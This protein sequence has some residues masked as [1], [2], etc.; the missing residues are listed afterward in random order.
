M[1]NLYNTLGVKDNATQEE[2]K[3]A[4]RKLAIK[5]HPD[6]G[7]NEDTFKKV[8]EAYGIL[9]DD[10][11]RSQY[12]NRN[13]NPFGGNPFGGQGGG[14]DPFGDFFRGFTQRRKK[15]TAPETI[16][17]VDV[18]AV[19]S[20]LGSEKIIT[21]TKKDKCDTCDGSGGEKNKCGICEG[22]G[23]RTVRVGSG[24]FSQVVRQTCNSCNGEGYIFKK[25]CGT[26]NGFMVKTVN[27]TVKIKLPVGIDNGQFLRLQGKGDYFKGMYGNLVIK[28]NLKP[29]K[30]FDKNGDSLIYDAVFDKDDLNK[31]N[32]IIPHPS[33]E[34]VVTMPKTFDTLKPLRVKSKGYNGGDLYVNLIVRFKR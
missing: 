8:N 26:C 11:K 5:H 27:E 13:N 16:V 19:E 22:E 17:N 7:G 23:F 4:Y 29:E 18:G 28:V 6:K 14:H 25:R 1:D 20:Y 33:G 9:S 24:L 34:L 30:G 32:Y 12:D 10:D 21:Y 31:D 3:K 15:P 2:I